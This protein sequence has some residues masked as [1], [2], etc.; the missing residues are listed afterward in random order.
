MYIQFPDIGWLQFPDIGWL[1]LVNSLACLTACV[2]VIVAFK[3]KS[4]K[5]QVGALRV[6]TSYAALTFLAS[7]Y[8]ASVAGGTFSTLSLAISA[9]TVLVL[10]AAIYAVWARGE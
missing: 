5:A 10:W 1:S 8:A 6:V 7:I 4:L 2:L 3:D 9:L